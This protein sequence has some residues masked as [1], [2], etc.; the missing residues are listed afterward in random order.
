VASS[1]AEGERLPQQVEILHDPAD[2]RRLHDAIRR[3]CRRRR[4]QLAL[5]LPPEDRVDRRPLP[6][7]VLLAVYQALEEPPRPSREELSHRRYYPTQLPLFTSPEV[8]GTSR[9]VPHQL[10]LLPELE[11]AERIA[12]SQALARDLWLEEVSAMLVERGVRDLYVLHAGQLSA[13]TWEWFCRL[14]RSASICL[15]LVV[16]GRGPHV[17]QVRALEGCRIQRR[18]A[19][20]SRRPMW[21]DRPNF[22]SPRRRPSAPERMTIPRRSRQAPRGYDRAISA[23]EPRPAPPPPSPVPEP[24]TPR[25]R[26]GHGVPPAALP[27]PLSALTPAELRERFRIAAQALVADNPERSFISILTPPQPSPEEMAARQESTLAAFAQLVAR[28]G[29]RAQ[30]FFPIPPPGGRAGGDEGREEDQE[31]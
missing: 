24:D 20:P 21:W 1:G 6:G 13:G 11:L 28:M 2:D 9:D 19:P 22:R 14:A 18:I 10:A 5:A 25:D 23:P 16:G 30:E 26:L 7:W 12:R 29:D 17:A 8:G 27:S 31:R 15:H 4:D 3:R